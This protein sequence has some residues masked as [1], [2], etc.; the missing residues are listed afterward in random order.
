[1]SRHLVLSLF[2]CATLSAA[3][4]AEKTAGLTKLEGYFPLY[5]D[6]KAGKMFLEIPALEMEFLYYSSLPSGLGSNDVGLDRGQIGGTHLVQFER[7]PRPNAERQTPVA[8][9]P[10]EYLLLKVGQSSS[11]AKARQIYSAAGGPLELRYVSASR[12]DL[13]AIWY[14]AFNPGPAALP[15]LTSSGWYRGPNSVSSGDIDV[16]VSEFLATALKV[17]G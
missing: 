7:N 13:I 16:K 10:D 6:A 4:I 11:F 3:T 14:Q 8:S 5:W 12:D 17:R 15:L 2:L 1:M 9:L